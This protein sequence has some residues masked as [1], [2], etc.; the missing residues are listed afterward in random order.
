MEEKEKEEAE[1]D[2]PEPTK[3]VA[4]KKAAKKEPAKKAGKKA[5]KKAP[6]H[7]EFLRFDPRK[8]KKGDILGLAKSYREKNKDPKGPFR[9]GEMDTLDEL[10]LRRSFVMVPDLATMAALGRPGFCTRR[11]GHLLG[12]EGSG[13]TTY[14]YHLCRVFLEAGGYACMVETEDAA[15]ALHMKS[16][17]GREH[18]D[19]FQNCFYSIRSLVRGLQVV[20]DIIDQQFAVAD[21]KGRFP[22]IIV[23]DTIA[24]ASTE[25]IEALTSS[26]IGSQKGGIATKARHVV[27]FLEYIKGRIHE[28][29][30]L[31]IFGNQAKE[32]IATGNEALFAGNK[33]KEDKISGQGGKSVDYIATYWDY[34]QRGKTIVQGGR[35]IGFE[36]HH[37]MK[38]NKMGLPKGGFTSIADFRRGVVYESST[39]KQLAAVPSL[40]IQKIKGP[41]YWSD[42]LG[43]GSESSP[44][45]EIEFYEAI[46]SPENI[47][48]AMAAVGG[49]VMPPHPERQV[50]MP[51]RWSSIPDFSGWDNDTLP[52]AG[53]KAMFTSEDIGIHD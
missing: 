6:A 20:C 16:V 23:Y 30:V 2:L 34:V 35:K 37:R 28:Q 45:S 52:S 49:I 43:I 5:S 47:A 22:K 24:G 9:E 17:V 39:M 21:P 31:L 7:L 29:N 19:E 42:V 33:P 13:K 48:Q 18:Y 27:R 14:M 3:P 26:D 1:D 8:E 53:G 50:W 10:E 40:G 4:A 51:K 32:K 15:S 25:E 12:F 36:T 38:K 11:I 41:K 44:L 46:H